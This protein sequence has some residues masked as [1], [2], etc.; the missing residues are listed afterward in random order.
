MAE[1]VLRN[2][3][4]NAIKYSK[5]YDSITITSRAEGEKIYILVSDEGLGME[6]EKIIFF[7]KPDKKPL[8]STLGTAREKG[9]G[10]GLLLCKTF[11]SLMKGTLQVSRN[12]NNQGLVFVLGLPKVNTNY[13]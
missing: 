6:E 12:K 10:L 11:A 13:K 8:K 4:S 3:L 5:A 9:T 7:N 1:L 2:L